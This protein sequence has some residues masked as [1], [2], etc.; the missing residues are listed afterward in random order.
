MSFS[1]WDVFTNGST[2]AV[3]NDTV[4]P[5]VG[6]GSLF[7]DTAGSGNRQAQVQVSDT[8]GIAK[9]LSRGIIRSVIN[10]NNFT[11][12]FQTG[13]I[14]L[15]SQEN[16]TGL[17]GSCYALT[18]RSQT[19][20]AIDFRLILQKYTGGLESTPTTLV[21]SADMQSS[22][23]T[24][25]LIQ[26]QWNIDLI[27]L[28]GVELV[29]SFADNSTDPNDLVDVLAFLDAFSPLITTVSEGLFCKVLSASTEQVEVRYD[30]TALYQ[31]V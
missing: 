16:V 11:A 28:G 23:M 3:T 1:D 7:F 13:I 30:D 14:C 15:L 5:L 2:I 29:A 26:L 24:N 31:L 10:V 4:S 21:E 20:G 27:G 18:L 8:S 22:V 9:G 6:S 12:G 17:S 25:S 19:S